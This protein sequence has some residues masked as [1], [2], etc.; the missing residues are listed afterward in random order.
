M[1]LAERMA[2]RSS[3]A[4]RGIKR[5]I[6]EGASLPLSTGLEIEKAEFMSAATQPG[7]RHAMVVY[8]EFVAG[9][10]ADGRDIGI[11]DFQAWIEGTAVDFNR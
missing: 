3:S 5:A 1:I 7:T 9:L 4:I 8:A 11:E 6:Y 10:V 2:R